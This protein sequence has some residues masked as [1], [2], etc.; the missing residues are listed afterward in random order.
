MSN[1]LATSVL[2][3]RFAFTWFGA[4]SIIIKLPFNSTATQAL[5][6]VMDYPRRQ[7][8][9]RFHENIY[10]AHDF[11]FDK[12]ITRKT[13]PD[14]CPMIVPGSASHATFCSDSLNGSSNGTCS[15]TYRS[16]PQTS[17]WCSHRH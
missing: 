7:F 17:Q 3:H 13:V 6:P 12:K 16:L 1:N 4:R 8:M 10:K 11:I 14:I 2:R 5:S 15:S 9:F